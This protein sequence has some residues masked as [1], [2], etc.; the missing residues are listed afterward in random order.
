MQTIQNQDRNGNDDRKYK[1]N[2]S[3][4]D[5]NNCKTKRINAVIVVF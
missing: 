5:T 4:N 1:N 3:K 2:N